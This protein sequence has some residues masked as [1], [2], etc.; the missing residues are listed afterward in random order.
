VG[1]LLQCNLGF[2]IGSSAAEQ[3]APPR[4]R[5]TFSTG[6]HGSWAPIA[7]EPGGARRQVLPR[8]LPLRPAVAISAMGHERRIGANAPAAGRPQTAD[9]A[10]GQRGFRLG[11]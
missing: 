2:R 8:K 10:G 3:P 5:S 6:R 7:R 9:P 11:P 4:G 1:R